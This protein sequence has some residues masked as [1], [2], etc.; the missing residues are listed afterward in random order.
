MQPFIPE[1]AERG[2]DVLFVSTLDP[3][4]IHRFQA[5]YGAQHM[6]VV[7]AGWAMFDL[8]EVRWIPSGFII[9]SD[10]AIRDSSSGWGTAS[11]AGLQD[12]VDELAPAG[13]HK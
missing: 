2:F 5:L 8:Y 10:G 9:D 13:E 11:L 7:V 3:A 4:Q 1:W 6:E 12:W